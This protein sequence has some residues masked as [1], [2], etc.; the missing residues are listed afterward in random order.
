M[1]VVLSYCYH[2]YIVINTVQCCVKRQR[3]REKHARGVKQSS[4]ES[5]HISM[6]EVEFEASWSVRMSCVSYW[7]RVNTQQW[8]P[9]ESEY[10]AMVY[11]ENIKLF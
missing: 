10:G 6:C 9:V 4:E 1:F 3:P 11:P 5:A 7:C 8:S 2:V